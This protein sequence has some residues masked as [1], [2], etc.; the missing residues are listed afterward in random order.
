MPPN[1]DN[2][3]AAILSSRLSQGRLRRLTTPSSDSVDFSSNSYLSLSSNPAVKAAYVSFI[4]P[5]LQSSGFGLGSGGSRLLDGNSAFTEDLERR[6]AEFHG[7]DAGLLFNSGF[8]ANTGLFACVPQKGDVIVYDELI[9]AS[10]HD[11]MRLS[12]AQRIAFAHNKV[13]DAAASSKYP[14]LDSLLKSLAQDT[15][16][17]SGK[18]NIFIAVEGVYSM[19]G[20]LAPLQAIVECVEKRLPRG[21]GYVIVDEAHSTGIFGRQGRGLVCQLGLEDRTWARVHTFGKAMGCSGGKF[22]FNPFLRIYMDANKSCIAIVLCSSTT[23]SYLINYARSFIYTTAMAFPSLASIRTTYD[24]LAQG[25]ADS[26]VQ[27]LQSLIHH[28]HT[29]LTQLIERHGPSPELF[30]INPEAPQ[31]PILPL[32]TSRARNL[33]QYCQERGFTV[34]PIVAPTVPAGQDRVRVCLH[35]GNTV[36]EVEGLC[37]AVEEWVTGAIKSKL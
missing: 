33:A 12:R 22:L 9:H 13:Y 16:V 37:R 20:D 29:L 34:R 17:S 21:N 7:A 5:H 28:M 35:A 11:G 30:R 24:F 27:N 6:I 32:L 23:R 8:E 2:T 4:L 3:L 31:S 25:H 36:E 26:L 15:Q 18:K 10:V 19:D 14:S 1:L